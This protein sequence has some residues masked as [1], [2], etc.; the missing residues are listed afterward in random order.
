[1]KKKQLYKL[2]QKELKKELKEQKSTNLEKPTGGEVL[3]EPKGG[4]VNPPPPAQ[5]AADCSNINVEPQ[6]IQVYLMDGNSA[7]GSGVDEFEQYF[8]PNINPYFSDNFG[9]DQGEAVDIENNTSFDGNTAITSTG[10]YCFGPVTI[11]NNWMCCVGDNPSAEVNSLFNIPS[12]E[13]MGGYSG[14]WMAGFAGNFPF[15]FNS[16]Q[17]CYCH[18]PQYD[19]YNSLICRKLDD[20]STDI[21]IT[22]AD[23]IGPTDYNGGGGW[24]SIIG[25]PNP[26]QSFF[27]NP[28]SM[29]PTIVNACVSGTGVEEYTVACVDD[30]YNGAAFDGLPLGALSP[31]PGQPACNYIANMD[32]YDSEVNYA[33]ENIS[34]DCDYGCF[35][36]IDNA[37]ANTDFASY[38]DGGFCQDLEGNDVECTNDGDNCEYS[39]CISDPATNTVNQGEAAYTACLGCGNSSESTYNYGDPTWGPDC[40]DCTGCNFL[41]YCGD[42]DAYNYVCNLN[43][44]DLGFGG[45][46]MDGIVSAL[47]DPL[48]DY[49]DPNWD[50]GAFNMIPTTD[51]SGNGTCLMDP[52]EDGFKCGDPTALNYDI[53]DG[54]ENHCE[55]NWC[56]IYAFCN[57]PNAVNYA[58]D[59]GH[60]GCGSG[61]SWEDAGLTFD[62]LVNMIWDVQVGGANEFIGSLGTAACM[63]YAVNPTMGNNN[64][65]PAGVNQSAFLGDANS[66]CKY[67]GCS[68]QNGIAFASNDGTQPPGTPIGAGFEATDCD[69][70]SNIPLFYHHPLN[71]GCQLYDCSGGDCVAIIDFLTGIP[72][73]SPLNNDCCMRVGCTDS[74]ASNWDPNATISMPDFNPLDTDALIGYNPSDLACVEDFVGIGLVPPGCEYDEQ[75]GCTDEAAWNYDEVATDDDDSCLY[76]YNIKA[77]QICPYSPPYGCGL[78]GAADEPRTFTR[79]AFKKSNGDEREIKIGD[80]FYENIAMDTIQGC[81]QMY[82]DGVEACNFDLCTYPST[83]VNCEFPPEGSDCDGNCQSGFIMIDGECESENEGC[84]DSDACNYN[85]AYNI[86]DGSCTYAEEGQDC[87]GEC[88]EDYYDDGDGNCVEMTFAYQGCQC[89]GQSYE[90]LSEDQFLSLHGGMV[91]PDYQG[92]TRQCGSDWVNED[93]RECRVVMGGYCYPIGNDL[94]GWT[95]VTQT[96]GEIV[97]IHNLDGGYCQGL[98]CTNNPKIHGHYG[99]PACK[100]DI[101]DSWSSVDT[102]CSGFTNNYNVGVMKAAYFCSPNDG[103]K[104]E[105]LFDY[106]AHTSVYNWPKSMQEYYCESFCTQ[107]DIG[108]FQALG[109]SSSSQCISQCNQSIT[110][111]G[112]GVYQWLAN[113]GCN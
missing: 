46:S 32:D 88:L 39:G 101:D 113:G 105:K 30:G 64:W 61:Y 2:I 87:Y 98:T 24:L 23:F 91:G 10:A 86:D 22:P 63:G 52:T 12:N 4:M 31:Y 94:M 68:D 73:L 82:V 36:C 49:A 18:N 47:C 96:C 9:F 21:D 19:E 35:G 110:T 59:I 16:G 60:P 56:C 108:G 78:D 1:M 100:H 55:G 95:G 109:C 34:A 3:P 77:K 65:L 74:N 53:I 90:T 66:I 89:C 54:V 20:L 11:P 58:G 104:F 7:P 43:N 51:A 33:T 50:I 79:V 97:N 76:T 6:Q 29:T 71:H 45:S 42:P 67:E 75:A 26:A 80:R 38:L 40:A 28:S 69:G 72:I 41:N 93:N 25:Q 37:A 17:A 92:N 83:M 57:D 85:V 13:F 14:N 111:G 15:E 84:T 5:Q 62:N 27:A 102:G 8:A 99:H 107:S 103:S 70:I 44:V 112:M 106:P 81:P 48:T